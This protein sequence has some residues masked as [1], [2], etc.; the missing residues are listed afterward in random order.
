MK[1]SDDILSFI[2]SYC[3]PSARLPSHVALEREFEYARQQI[4]QFIR[5]THVSS[6][7]HAISISSPGLWADI[8]TDSIPLLQR[9]LERSKAAVSL[10]LHLFGPASWRNLHRG[11]RR[12]MSSPEVQAAYL[13]ALDH[14]TRTRSLIMR[15]LDYWR[16]EPKS[17]IEQVL[18]GPAP[19]LQEVTLEGKFELP[20]LL[21]GDQAPRLRR[22]KLN[23]VSTPLLG[24]QA[25]GS[26]SVLDLNWY[27][28]GADKL[29]HIPPLL[30]LL[31]ETPQLE[32]FC[33]QGRQ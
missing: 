29:V 32:E 18:Q 1:L 22:L 19:L 11:W 23:D 6:R 4:T 9:M 20:F 7:W 14:L 2:I 21:F 25:L 33:F 13:Q 12:G 10:A 24:W 27:Q 5:L 8:C 26:L 15:E 28:N 3:A 31:R 16:G 17:H 30:E